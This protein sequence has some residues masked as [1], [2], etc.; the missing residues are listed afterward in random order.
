VGRH[1]LVPAEDVPGTNV[2]VLK[3]FSPKIFE[4]KNRV[5]LFN[6]I[7]IFAKFAS[8]IGF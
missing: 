4:K 8:Y 6:V 7:L 5:F 2:M 1:R 3:I